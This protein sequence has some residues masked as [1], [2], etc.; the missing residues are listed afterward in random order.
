[1]ISDNPGYDHAFIN[2]YGWR[3]LNLAL[4]G[5]S[6]RRINDIWAGF[7]KNAGATQG[8]KKLRKTKHTHDPLDDAMSMAEALLGMKNKHGIKFPMIP[9]EQP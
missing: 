1:M 4:L 5:H 9:D 3:F 2:W 8:W 7:E 6:A